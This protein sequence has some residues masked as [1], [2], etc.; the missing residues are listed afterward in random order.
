VSGTCTHIEKDGS[1]Y[2]ILAYGVQARWSS[3]ETA[4]RNTA[5]SFQRLTDANVINVQPR[6]VD[7]VRIN[8]AMTLAQF[9]QRN[10]GSATLDELEMLNQTLRNATIPSGSYVKNVVGQRVQ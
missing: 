7:I 3:Y 6:R 4:T 1:V 10:P 5:Q 2:Q 9:A 8:S